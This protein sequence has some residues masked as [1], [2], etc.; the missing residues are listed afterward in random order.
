MSSRFS[1]RNGMG[2]K[3][4]PRKLYKYRAF[5]VHSLRLITQAELFYA[6]PRGFNDPL[7]CNPTIA[8]DVDRM[9]VESLCYE[10]VARDSGIEEA[11]ET[12]QR[13]RFNS[14]EYGDYEKD[15]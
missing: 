15:A 3:S 13:C 11:K 2:I 7:D 10:L 6:D 8:V 14:T 5:N 9:S 4:P 1:E 12:I